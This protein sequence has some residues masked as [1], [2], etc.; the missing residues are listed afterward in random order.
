MNIKHLSAFLAVA[1]SRSFTQAARLLG[2]A[3]PTVTTR[4]KSLEQSLETPLLERTAEGARL[5]PAGRRLQ[6][7]ARRIVHLSQLAKES[8]CDSADAPPTLVVG[9][10]E[11]LTTYR[12]LPLIEH[13]H[14]RHPNLA[15][16]LRALDDDPVA[17][18]RDEQV[19]CA[20][21]IGPRTELPAASSVHHRV[22]RP[23]RLAL[24]AHPAHPLTGVPIGSTRDLAGHTLACAH[25]SSGY[26]RG[27]EAELAAVGAEPGCVLGLGSVDAVKRSVGDGIG[28]A[29][30]PEVTVA[31]ELRL[32]RLRRIAWRPAFEVYAQCVWRRGLDDDTLFH[33]VL[34]TA[35]Q[36]MTEQ[37]GYEDGYE[38]GHRG[39]YEGARQGA[40]ANRP[41][42]AAG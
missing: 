28:M 26:Q 34:T 33:T 8:V 9:A 16:T 37:D 17:L 1:E 30:L 13:L 18:V 10:A 4:I 21:F 25:R 7:Y 22:L 20:F 14:L 2:L 12:L 41:L 29:L 6:R 40:Y 24:V 27:L 23:E 15:L 38:V 42:Q 31:E 5:T 35:R 36:V 11:C 3:Q 19:D 32:G 39:G